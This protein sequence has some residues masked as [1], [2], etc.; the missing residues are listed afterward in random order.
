MMEVRRGPR[1]RLSLAAEVAQKP[2]GEVVKIMQAL[3]QIGI[4]RL[5]KA[6]PVLRFHPLDRSLGCEAR[7]YVGAQPLLPAAIVGEEAVG[8]E[9]F[10]GNPGEAL[11]SQQVVN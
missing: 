6:G 3:A 7:E 10:P 9:H 2:V 4:T 8:F 5:R 11:V 1:P